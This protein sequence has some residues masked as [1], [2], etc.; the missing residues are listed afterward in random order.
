MHCPFCR[1]EDTRVVD[2]RLT[3]EGDQVRRR[4]E[5]TE[6]GARFNTFESP[7]LKLPAVV[8]HDGRREPFSE[9][10]LRGGVKRALEKRPVPTEDVERLISR[11]MRDLRAAGRPEVPSMQIGELVMAGLRE[12]DQVAYVRFAS[13]YRR[14]QDVQ[15]FREEI[16]RLESSV[17]DYSEAQLSLLEGGEDE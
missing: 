7:Q 15:A 17:P 4:R 11:I 14:F 2:S 12:L 1:A 5:C 13:V 8:K 6:C 10:K 16:E 3:A 9:D